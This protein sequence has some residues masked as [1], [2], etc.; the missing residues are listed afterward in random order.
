[1]ADNVMTYRVTVKRWSRRSSASTPLHAQAGAGVNG[2]G[3]HTHQSLFDGRPNAFFGEGDEYHLSTTRQGTTIA[4]I[5][6]G[7]RPRSRSSRTSG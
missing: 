2:C 6:S 5:L 1:M 7:T 3:M 4:G